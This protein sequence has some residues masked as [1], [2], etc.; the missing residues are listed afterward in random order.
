MARLPAGVVRPTQ[1]DVL[2][3]NDDRQVQALLD[4]QIGIAW[5]TSLAWVMTGDSV[6]FEAVE[7]RGLSRDW[8]E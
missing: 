4:R 1:R 3:S 2:D 6:R 8:P 7:R 5:S